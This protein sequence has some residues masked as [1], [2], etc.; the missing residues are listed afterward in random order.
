MA[1]IK[2]NPPAMIVADHI[3]GCKAVQLWTY[4]SADAAATVA[5]AGYFSNG[6]Q[7]GMRVND[8][9]F[10]IDTAT[11]LTTGHR[12]TSLAG[13]DA[14][15][16]NAESRRRPVQVIMCCRSVPSSVA[17]IRRIALRER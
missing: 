14:A 11:P 16:P 4:V 9:I 10:V 1:Y 15:H 12:V 13:I 5:G 3:P 2:S 6:V 8:F 7:L 17:P